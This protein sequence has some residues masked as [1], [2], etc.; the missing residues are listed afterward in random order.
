MKSSIIFGFLAEIFSLVLLEEGKKFE[1]KKVWITKKVELFFLFIWKHSCCRPLIL[2][3]VPND[4]EW[5]DKGAQF[6][7]IWQ[8]KFVLKCNVTILKT[9]INIPNIQEWAVSGP[10]MYYY[11][12]LM[13]K[14]IDNIIIWLK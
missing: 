13:V 14:L 9:I 10:I 12:S 11:N 4:E 6:N 7:W 8:W 2:K 1:R 5:N 3:H